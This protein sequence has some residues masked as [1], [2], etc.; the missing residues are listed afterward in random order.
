MKQPQDT[1]TDDLMARLYAYTRYVEEQVHELSEKIEEGFQAEQAQ[2]HKHIRYLEEQVPEL[3]KQI[4]NIQG[5]EVDFDAIPLCSADGV[6]RTGGFRLRVRRPRVRCARRAGRPL[7]AR[8]LLR[9]MPHGGWAHL[10]A[11]PPAARRLRHRGRGGQLSPAGRVEHQPS[12]TCRT[13]ASR[14]ARRPEVR[15]GRVGVLGQSK[16]CRADGE[17]R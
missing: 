15:P 11:Q 3:N 13:T 8:A 2:N 14:V 9:G 5:Q 7:R 17:R 6:R 4:T 1:S 10:R 16:A 12:W